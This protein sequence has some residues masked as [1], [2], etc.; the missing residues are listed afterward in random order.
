MQGGLTAALGCADGTVWGTMRPA[1]GFRVAKAAKRETQIQGVETEL[2]GGSEE[3][4]NSIIT[5]LLPLHHLY[6]H[7]TAP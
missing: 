2:S 4:N 7:L 3:Q 5:A 6:Q 1:W